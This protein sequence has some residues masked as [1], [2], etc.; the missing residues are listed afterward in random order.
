MLLS[1]QTYC[2]HKQG[3]YYK[4]Q[5]GETIYRI[6]RNHNIDVNALMA[7]NE[8]K[9]P[10]S[11]KQ[12]TL[13]Y[14]P[15]QKAIPQMAEEMP[16][17]SAAESITQVKNIDTTRD[18]KS[19]YVWPVHGRVITKFG[20]ASEKKYDGVNIEGLWGEEVRAISDGKVLYSGSGVKGYGN[21]VIIRHGGRLYSVYALNSENLVSK[22][23]EVRKSQVIAKVGGIPRIGKSFLHFQI[24]D[25]KKA[26]DPLNYLK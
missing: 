1:S 5:K 16:S 18:D 6:A 20:K 9:E 8:I 10:S 13:L 24:R 4:V 2:M 21:M 22:G 3:S 25:G 7:L 19:K 23:D 12:G 11:L 14:I 26:V 15:N 17:S